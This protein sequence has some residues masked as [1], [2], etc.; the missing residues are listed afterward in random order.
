[1]LPDLAG[2]ASG[3]LRAGA[4]LTD[5][6]ILTLDGD[7]D[8]VALPANLLSGLT[9]VSVMLWVRYSGG[10][11]YVRLFDFGTSSAGFDPPEGE[12]SVGRSYLALTPATGNDPSGLAALAATDGAGSEV[13][14]SSDATLGDDEWHQVTVVLDGNE[15]ELRLYLDAGLMVTSDVEHTAAEIDNENNWLGR[16]QYD[17]DPYIEISYD[18]VRIYNDALAPCAIAT[19]F[20]N[21]PDVP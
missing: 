12:P 3:E 1:M 18:E 7:D 21:G 14:A 16:S 9:S 10:P 20:A 17:A 5:E 6:G 2:Q 15:R 8:F 11:A 13:L 4:T 19:A